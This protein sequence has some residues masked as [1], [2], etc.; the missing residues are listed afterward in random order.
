MVKV[1]GAKSVK[2]RRELCTLIEC[3]AS[4]LRIQYKVHYIYYL[5][6]KHINTSN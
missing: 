1:T 6:F 5:T 4:S 3:T 2:G